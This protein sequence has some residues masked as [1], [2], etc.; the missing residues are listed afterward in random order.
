MELDGLSAMQNRLQN[1][2]QDRSEQQ[3]S[4]QGVQGS[5]EQAIATK[6][7]RRHFD[8]TASGKSSKS[9]AQLERIVSNLEDKLPA[10][11]EIFSNASDALKLHMSGNANMATTANLAEAFTEAEAKLLTLETKLSTRYDDLALKLGDKLRWEGADDEAQGE[12]DSDM[13]DTQTYYNHSEALHDEIN[14]RLKELAG[15][16]HGIRKDVLSA[17]QSDTAAL[18]AAMKDLLTKIADAALL[19]VSTAALTTAAQV[20]VDDANAAE[21][22]LVI[23]LTRAVDASEQIERIGKIVLKILVQTNKQL[24]SLTSSVQRHVIQAEEAKSSENA[25]KL[26]EQSVPAMDKREEWRMQGKLTPAEFLTAAA[27]NFEGW[28]IRAQA[29]FDWQERMTVKFMSSLQGELQQGK[30]MLTEVFLAV[31]GYRGKVAVSANAE[32]QA[33]YNASNMKIIRME[34]YKLETVL[35]AVVKMRTS[36]AKS[37]AEDKCTELGRQLERA[38]ASSSVAVM[39]TVEGLK[40]QTNDAQDGLKLAS[41]KEFWGGFEATEL[42]KKFCTWANFYAPPTMGIQ[43]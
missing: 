36:T 33:T 8:G 21:E 11:R 40:N 9:I 20:A 25:S 35:A 19:N 12:R 38:E 2:L 3:V 6:G 18:D 39:E 31:V 15:V 43:C 30:K 7:R 24:W 27:S 1:R 4:Q 42:P 29:D 26:E 37:I 16:F 17:A 28:R 32:I 41:D 10:A 14:T 23:A 5:V 34:L 13:A 22:A